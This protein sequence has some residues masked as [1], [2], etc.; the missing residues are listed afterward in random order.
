[1]C[2][3]VGIGNPRDG[4]MQFAGANPPVLGVFDHLCVHDFKVWALA[5]FS[6]FEHDTVM[7]AVY[8]SLVASLAS[9]SAFSLPVT[10]E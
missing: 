9:L 6:A 4:G 3:R 1:M 2:F 8:A 7:S 5:L 10:S